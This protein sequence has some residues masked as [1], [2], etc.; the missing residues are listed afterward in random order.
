M[1]KHWESHYANP[2]FRK[3]RNTRFHE[4]WD[5]R[6]DY[7]LT[8][9]TGMPTEG[10]YGPLNHPVTSTTIIIPDA[11]IEQIIR[12]HEQP[13]RFYARTFCRNQR[14]RVINYG[15]HARGFAIQFADIAT[16]TSFRLLFPYP[17]QMP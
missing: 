9:S 6:A 1:K 15:N 2:A 13:V 3:S 7:S 17:T 5:N 11:A 4:R 16:A 8:W 10:L 12:D 14:M